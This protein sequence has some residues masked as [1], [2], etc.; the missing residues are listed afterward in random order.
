MV[1]R[2]RELLLFYLL[3][4]RR[5]RFRSEGTEFL[6]RVRISPGRWGKENLCPPSAEHNGDWLLSS[7]AAIPSGPSTAI[8][9]TLKQ[10]LLL[11]LQSALDPSVKLALLIYISICSSGSL[12]RRSL[13]M[14]QDKELFSIPEWNTEEL[15]ANPPLALW[16]SI[17]KGNVK[18][19]YTGLTPRLF[20]DTMEGQV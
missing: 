17:N 10:K 4:D 11:R 15:Q 20:I 19:P 3:P 8:L 7:A 6:A 14:V 16:H 18:I 1:T 9:S 12:R 13:H 2:T 5:S